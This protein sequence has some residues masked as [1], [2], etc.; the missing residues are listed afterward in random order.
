MLHAS[1]DKLCPRT[2]P[3]T[4]E[5]VELVYALLELDGVRVPCGDCAA[6]NTDKRC[7]YDLVAAHHVEWGEVCGGGRPQLVV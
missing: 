3:R 1:H 7:H 5:V 2:R 6:D 4:E